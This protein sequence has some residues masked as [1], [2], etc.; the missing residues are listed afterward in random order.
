MEKYE[1]FNNKFKMNSAVIAIFFSFVASFFNSLAMILFKIS[2]LRQEVTKRHYLLSWY[3]IGALLI[4][5]GAAVVSTTTLAYVDV[6]TVSSISA[7]DLVF[8]SILA[9]LIL[10][11]PFTK[12][13]LVSLFLIIIGSLT[14]LLNSAI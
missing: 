5:V 1:N 6:I 10:K 11:E 13:D 3:F 4:I 2:H 12:Y 8:N 7:S 9:N 14:C